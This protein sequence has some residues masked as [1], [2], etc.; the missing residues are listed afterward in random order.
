[1]VHNIKYINAKHKIQNILNKTLYET[2]Y[3]TSYSSEEAKFVAT[4]ATHGKVVGI[5]A[6]SIISTLFIF[7]AILDIPNLVQAYFRWKHM[8]Q[9]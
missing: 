4:E 3:H 9:G 5:V 6:G 8:I 2:K 1:M 7:F